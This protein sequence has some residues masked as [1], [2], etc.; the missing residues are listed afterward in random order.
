MNVRNMISH[1]SS[2]GYPIIDADLP[3]PVYNNN[4]AC[5]KWWLNMTTNGNQHVK[6]RKN[7]VK[8]WVEYDSVSVSHMSGKSN[9]SNIFTKEMQDSASFRHLRN[10]FMSRGSYFLLGSASI[11]QTTGSYQSPSTTTDCCTKCSIHPSFNTRYTQ[12]SPL[13]HMLP[14]TAEPILPVH[15]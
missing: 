4:E 5:V 2:I 1:Q 6:H 11:L 12:C 14:S 15:F 8:E 3:L 7:V 10:S 13:V 9:P